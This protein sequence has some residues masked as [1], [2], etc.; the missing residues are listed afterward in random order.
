MRKVSSKKR[1]SKMRVAARVSKMRVA[2]RVPEHGHR[3]RVIARTVPGEEGSAV[4]AYRRGL[5]DGML[6]GTWMIDQV[7]QA[8]RPERLPAK[9]KRRALKRSSS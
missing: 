2:A 3:Y 7:Q 6:L 4:D 9:K 1:V 5:A 8:Q